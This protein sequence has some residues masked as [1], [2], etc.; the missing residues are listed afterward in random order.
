M[1]QDGRDA[2]PPL[3]AGESASSRASAVVGDERISVN[4]RGP[5]RVWEVEA[6]L[7]QASGVVPLMATTTWVARGRTGSMVTLWTV[8]GWPPDPCLSAAP[9]TVSRKDSQASRWSS[10]RRLA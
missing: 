4:V 7:V 2:C 3:F 5:V 6:T 8:A 9:T 10:Q 1:P